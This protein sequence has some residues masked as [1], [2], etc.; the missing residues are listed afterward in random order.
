[1]P[2]IVA[3]PASSQCTTIAIEFAVWPDLGKITDFLSRL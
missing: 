1:M 3:A 2:S